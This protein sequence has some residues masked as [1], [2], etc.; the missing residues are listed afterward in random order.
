MLLKNFTRYMD[1]VLSFGKRYSLH[2]RSRKDVKRFDNCCIL[3]HNNVD[4]RM[5][6]YFDL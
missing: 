1:L 2:L 5:V 4:L 6:L 3:N